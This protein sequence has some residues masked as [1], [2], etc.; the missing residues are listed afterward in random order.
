[1]DSD[2][3]KHEKPSGKSKVSELLSKL[4]K[5]RG[6][7]KTD[8]EPENAVTELVYSDATTVAVSEPDD[9]LDTTRKEVDGE[10]SV[11]LPE[12]PNV[13]EL[14][15]IEEYT[16]EITN[17]RPYRCEGFDPRDVPDYVQYDIIPLPS[18][19]ECYPHKKNCLPVAYL[20]AADENII[21]SPNIYNNGNL[22]DILLERKILDKS[23]RV[24]DL[25]KGDRDAIIVWLRAT[26]YGPEYPIVARYEGKEFETTVDL[27]KLK[28]KPFGLVGD[29]NGY[30]DYVTDSGDR[31]KFKFLTADEENNLFLANKLN[32]TILNTKDVV[33]FCTRMLVPIRAID[34]NNT[35]DIVEAVEGIQKWASDIA[36]KHTE[37]ND[38]LVYNNVVTSRMAAFTMS[39]NGNTDRVF[40]KNYIENMRS[41]EARKYREY[42]NENTPCMD[43]NVEIEIPESM[44]GGSFTTFLRLGES[45]FFNVL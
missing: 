11:D 37:M 45:I 31:L 19:G 23:V 38:D 32:Y 18:K 34:D 3:P 16:S 40:I 17:E 20:T 26:A 28:F 33:D 27:S 42:V 14:H 6:M 41:Y 10:P 22:M 4:D 5:V 15:S 21:A 12:L 2:A 1:M 24:A 44:G 35:N 36:S 30:F 8:S 25:T 9:R 7:R 39:V 13:R 43:F 29:E